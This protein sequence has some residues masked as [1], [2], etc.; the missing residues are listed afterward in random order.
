VRQNRIV[1]L[2]DDKIDWEVVVGG[3]KTLNSIE[4]VSEFGVEA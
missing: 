3:L 1:I 4:C 2:Q